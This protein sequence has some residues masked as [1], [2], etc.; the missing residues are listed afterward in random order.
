MGGGDRAVGGGDRAGTVSTACGWRVRSL[1]SPRSLPVSQ[2][3]GG[4]RD[5]VLCCHITKGRSY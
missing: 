2:E 4:K 5:L 3:A 1:L